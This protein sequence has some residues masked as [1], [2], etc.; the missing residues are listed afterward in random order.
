V[1]K[2]GKE[3][4]AG[5]V[6]GPRKASALSSARG[7][8]G[9][10]AGIEYQLDV[11][12][13]ET[14]F[15]ILRGLLEPS[16]A[17]VISFES[18]LADSSGQVGFDFSINP[19]NSNA[20][21]KSTPTREDIEEWL[22]LLPAAFV[23]S[24]NSAYRFIFGKSC[25]ATVDLTE[26]TR[27]AREARDAEHFDQLA[28]D[29][30]S[31]EQQSL[32]RL[33]GDS[34]WEVARRIH[35]D[36]VGATE[37]RGI[38]DW[39]ATQ[40]AGAAGTRLVEMVSEKFRRGGKERRSFPIS[41]LIAE[42]RSHGI[43]LHAPSQISV[44]GSSELASL[45]IVMHSCVDPVP[46]K[47][48]AQAAGISP[49]DALGVLKGHIEADLVRI[50]GEV[51]ELSLLP[52]DITSDRAQELLSRAL[53]A[54][55]SLADDKS[56]RAAILGQLRNIAR[57]S[58]RCLESDPELVASVFPKLDKLVKAGGDFHLILNLAHLS[59]RAAGKPPSD[60]QNPTIQMLRDRA[61]TLIC[62]ISWV[63][64]RVD[65][66]RI[67]RAYGEE[68]LRLGEEIGWQR[69][70]AFC[71]KCL[72]RVERMDAEST[73]ESDER[74]KL[75]QQSIESL[76]AA[77]PLFASLTD[78]GMGPDCEDIGECWS[79]IARTLLVFGDL[80][81]VR[82]AM[83]KAYPIL[84]R[85]RG[86]KAWADLLILD[87]DL[88]LL[89]GHH[90]IALDRSSEVLQEIRSEE[91][92]FSEI[93]ARALLLLART[94]ASKGEWKSAA[95]EFGAA[96]EQY[97]KLSDTPKAARARWNELQ[98]NN[99]VSK[100]VIPEDLARLLKSEKNPAVC[101]QAVKM[102]HERIRSKSDRGSLSQRAGAS[103]SYLT[104]L[105][106]EAQLEAKR[107]ESQWD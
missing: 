76:Q 6:R 48:L 27:A 45:L 9:N 3:G 65:K 106:E 107:N 58:E 87:G 102:Y 8:P 56:K 68:S 52:N 50:R 24:G 88:E 72:G 92:D 99:R 19:D 96:A 59:V 90:K 39:R 2:R 86:S 20:E 66:L 37:V 43:H 67:A 33:L 60:G 100:G 7:G 103:E 54:L 31:P 49:D 53:R 28:R 61:Q 47:V 63:Y 22:T 105:I 42:I 94:Y 82:G 104:A 57:L 18:R 73:G 21:C 70:T 40:L 11:A 85:F 1:A 16:R 46:V 89:A 77:I 80:P 26:V 71:R 91:F 95:A 78:E 97:E 51:A 93:R 25:Q 84:D 38:V 5:N 30:L 55:L 10:F 81:A 98:A 34:A 29:T 75:L 79:L 83:Q 35:A 64:Q 44:D 15:L 13:N 32:I 69:N 17:D 74:K 4:H 12:V 41:E 36:P 23:R 14:L 62:G 101:V